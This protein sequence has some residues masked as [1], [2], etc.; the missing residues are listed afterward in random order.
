M[1]RLLKMSIARIWWQDDAKR[2]LVS[3]ICMIVGIIFFAYFATGEAFR[4]DSFYYR[5][6]I[7]IVGIILY[8][9]GMIFAISKSWREELPEYKKQK[10][11]ERINKVLNEA[12][13]LLK[14]LESDGLDDD[15]KVKKL[16][17]FI[18]L[19]DG[20]HLDV[21]KKLENWIINYRHWKN[22]QS[23]ISAIKTNYANLHEYENKLKNFDESLK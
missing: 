7:L 19:C 10:E 2:S 12:D 17:G 13:I 14:E 1:L 23:T 3:F 21:A 16:K 11:R 18:Y 4:I 5:F 8:F 15:D 20:I 6:E 22:T 9:T